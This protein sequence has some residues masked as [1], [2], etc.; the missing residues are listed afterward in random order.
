MSLKIKSKVDP[1]HHSIDVNYILETV[2]MSLNSK[3]FRLLVDGTEVNYV[4]F[5]IIGL[6]KLKN[7]NPDNF[8]GKL[9]RLY[10]LFIN[11]IWENDFYNTLSR[12]CGIEKIDFSNSFD[13]FNE[14]INEYELRLIGDKL[15]KI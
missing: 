8:K 12:I 7:L 11:P 3:K 2:V 6:R 15:V 1:L 10:N 14:I 9:I 5:A 4:E 13:V